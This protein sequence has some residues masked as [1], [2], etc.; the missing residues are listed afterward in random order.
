MIG[1]L[2]A[3]EV[4]FGPSILVGTRIVSIQIG[5]ASDQFGWQKGFVVLSSDLQ[6][7]L[8]RV[9]ASLDL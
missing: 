8:R 3:L 9:S 5:Q 1:K 2:V 7:A 4:A 6:A